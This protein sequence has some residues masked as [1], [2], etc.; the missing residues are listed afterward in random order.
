METKT[1]KR[2]EAIAKLRE[3]LKPGDTV[4]CILR[5][6]SRSGMMRRLDVYKPD[7][8]ADGKPWQRYLTALVADALGYK[9]RRDENGIRVSGCGMDMGWHVV[10]NL[11]ATLYP[12]GFG[13]TGK[14]CPSNDHSNGDRD[15]TPHEFTPRNDEGK[16]HAHWHESGDYALRME[17]L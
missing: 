16:N 4:Y 15:Y 5:H 10:F 11:S 6:V 17:W 9:L 1:N 14:R 2:A 3:I 12:D 13:C 7:T 8:D